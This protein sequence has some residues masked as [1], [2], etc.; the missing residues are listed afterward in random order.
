MSKWSIIAALALR[1]DRDDGE[2]MQR[3]KV[4]CEFWNDYCNFNVSG[5]MAR[6]LNMNMNIECLSENYLSQA[7][8]H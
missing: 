6:E 8:H 2:R 1:H 4:R 5:I 3:D 7:G